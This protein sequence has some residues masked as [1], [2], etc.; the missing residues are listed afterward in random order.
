MIVL[1]TVSERNQ[2]VSHLLAKVTLSECETII[3]CHVAKNNLSLFITVNFA[4]VIA[5]S[6][7]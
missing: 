4:E 1:P 3:F 7:N 6:T 2:G 5:Q